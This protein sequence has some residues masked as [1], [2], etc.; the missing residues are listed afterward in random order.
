MIKNIDHRNVIHYGADSLIIIA[1]KNEF[2]KPYC[3]KILNDEFPAAEV[4]AQ[5]DNEYELCSA[6]SASSIRKAFQKTSIENHHAIALEFIEGTDLKKLLSGKRGTLAYQINLVA[7]IAAALSEIEKENIFHGQINPSN[8]LVEKGTNKIYFVDFGNACQSNSI[9]IEPGTT[10]A[11]KLE[12]LRY[13]APEQTGRI[14]KTIDSRADLYSLGIVFYEIFTG[15]TPFDSNDAIELLYGHIAK[16]PVEPCLL[17]KELPKIV[18]DIIMKL[19]AK[20][21]EDRYQSALGVYYDLE[22][23]IN[24]LQQNEEVEP[25]ALGGNDFSGKYFTQQKLY[26]RENEVKTLFSVFEECA[27][28]EK[29]LLLVSGYSGS[30]KSALIAEVQKPITGKNGL[31]VKGKF[32]QIRLDTPYSAF[33]QAFS[34]LANHILTQEQSLQFQWKKRIKEAI[35]NTGIVLTELVPGIE[36]LIGKQDE[37]AD[38]KGNEAQNRFNYTLL[39][40]IKAAA[41]KKQPLV[42]FID[43]LQ[44]ADASSLNLLK[45]IMSDRDLKYVMIIGSYRNNE[46]NNDHPLAK[47]LAELNQDGVHHDEIALEDLS[48]KDVL[49][50]TEDLLHT[51]QN[52][53]NLLAE[54]VYNKTKGNPFYVHQFLKSVYEEKLLH[55][56]FDKQIWLWNKEMIL[57]MNVSGN[58]VDLMTSLVQKLPPETVGLLKIAACIGNRFDRRTLSLINQQNEKLVTKFLQQPLSDGLI[59]LAGNQYKFAHDRI[60]QAIYTLIE[61]AEKKN[62]HLSIAKALS[63]TTTENEL[64][65]KIFDI[66]NQ[67]NIAVGLVDNEDTKLYLANLNLMAARKAVIS[68]AYP[69]ALQYFEKSLQLT[70]ETY[71]QTQ[72]DFILQL[73]GEAAEAAYFCGEYD[74]VDAWVNNIMQY[75]RSLLDS[76]KGYEVSIKKLI[77]QTK[78][79]D[80][81]SLGLVILNKMGIKFSAKPGKA[82]TLIGLLQ[83]KW[84]LRKKTIDYFTNLPEM[85]DNEKNAVMRILSDISSAAYFAAPQLVPLLIF[86]MVRLTVKH[87]LSRKSPYSFAAYGFILSAYMGETDNGITYGQIALN[88]AKKLKA[89]ELNASIMTTNNVFLTHWR[90]PLHETIDDLEKAFKSSLESG[91]TE[92]GSY[93]AHNMAYQ[94]F[95]MGFPLNDLAKRTE[96]LDT[97]IEKF[98]QN[99]TIKRLRIFRQSIYNLINETAHPEVLTGDIFNETEISLNDISENNK[100]YFQ[101]LYFQKLFLALVF[102]LSDEAYKHAETAGRFHESVRGSAIYPLYYF[103][104]ALAISGLFNGTEGSVKKRDLNILRKD[105]YLMKKFEKLSPENYTY[106]R[107][108]LEAEYNQITGDHD[109]AKILY[110]EALKAASENNMVHDLAIC[111]ERAAKFFL[112]TK[113][114]VLA[115]F[116]LQNSYKTYLRWGAGAKLKQMLERYPLLESSSKYDL[117]NE[118]ISHPQKQ[119]AEDLDLTTVIKASLALSGEIVLSKLLKKLMQITLESAGA[120]SGFVI[121][122]KNDERYIEAEIVSGREEIKT[123]Q[124]IPVNHCGVLAESVVNYVY[125]TKE[126]VML[127]NATH[128]DLFANDDYIKTHRSKSI[129]CVPLLNQGKL[130]GI[131][132]LSNDLIAGAFTEKRLALLKLLTGQIAISIENAL[133]YT[134]LENKVRQRT[135]ELQIEKQKSDDLLLN[136]LPE[137]IADELKRTGR[138]RPRSYEMTTVM[139]TDFKDFTVQS[140]KLPAEELVLLIDTCFKKFDEIISKHHLEKI[141]TIGDAYLC[142]S[143][144]PNPQDHNAE[145]VVR[146]AMEIIEFMKSVQE[147]SNGSSPNYFDIRIGI[148]SG[149]LVAG[150]VGNKKFAYDI[151]GDTVNTAARMEQNSDTNRINIS[152]YTYNLVKDKFI[153]TFRGKQP[154]KNKGLIDMYF[155]D[156]EVK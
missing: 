136:I 9:S 47:M 31:F 130:Q 133:F 84:A 111:W 103:Y 98:R 135:N 129:L 53:A 54:I 61:E 70:N 10:K 17:N 132:Y 149:P 23:C 32:D 92:W 39:N 102:N 147:G 43:D 105:I 118:I 99:L 89:D 137:E 95:I 40:F 121:M 28:G 68:A 73:T 108:L 154:A 87:G 7:E 5:L 139:F 74:K 24:S 50:L 71:W 76:T 60:Q 113:Q 75:S 116:Y 63:G 104:R 46:I 64:P 58:V 126:V 14:N 112:N 21:A 146:A 48:Y 78:L 65:D 93:A 106:K 138:T 124:S 110:D 82:A 35:G 27:A 153:C 131:I 51:R 16:T 128:S 114:E 18:S 141:K 88:L 115:R 100:V 127:D 29:K 152:E 144:L 13:I 148:N 77:A 55:F 79:L 97:Q 90:K 49:N 4:V 66:V 142:V 41:R 52:N 72:Y 96:M 123:L 56:D 1:K 26:G 145:N 57:Q 45:V 81:I 62:I 19:L 134:D 120:Q 85:D 155:V 119:L 8:I 2:S 36:S 150:V 37:V 44:W 33:V 67:W 107:F 156:G 80:A 34:E 151:W 122:E 91:D 117:E 6:P 3:L 86:K 30:G 125:L 25:F 12:S 83:T 101:N 69:Q 143:G 38:L 94:L 140:E 42:I 20:N 11:P 15:S 22:I 109:Q 59:I